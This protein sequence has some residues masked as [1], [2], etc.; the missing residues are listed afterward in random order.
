MKK[1]LSINLL[2]ILILTIIGVYII[3]L[4][5]TPEVKP[6]Y[7]RKD[8]QFTDALED[9]D[10]LNKALKIMKEQNCVEPTSWYYQ[11]AIHWV[12][13]TIK[14]INTPCLAYENISDL[15]PGWDAC[16]H[17]RTGAEEVN[18]LIWHRLY[19][20]HFEKIV[21][22]LSGKKDFALPYWNYTS[23]IHGS[24]SKRL[25]FTFRDT[26]SYLYESAR[27]DSINM[28]FPIRGSEMLNVLDTK[29]LMSQKTH[30]GFSACIDNG[31]HGAMHDYIGGATDTTKLYDNIITRS[32]TKVG[33]MGWVPTAAFDPVF[34]IHHANVD[35]LW[36]KWLTSKNGQNTTLEELKE[37]K[38]NFVFFDENGKQVTYTPEDIIKIIYTMDYDYDYQEV[39]PSENDKFIVRLNNPNYKVVDNKIDSSVNTIKLLDVR[40]SRIKKIDITVSFLDVPRGV[41]EVHLNSDTTFTNENIVGYMSF[42][43]SDHRSPG[44]TCI[45]GCC[46]E[47]INGRIQKKF[48]YD[49]VINNQ[50]TDA[51]TQINIIKRNKKIHNDLKIE[52]VTIF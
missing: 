45:R 2:I 15:R 28:G 1:F 19:I 21:R 40:A 33:L 46:G 7:V 34:W 18:F 10:A 23:N 4:Y 16:T 5:S 38:W 25:N 52:N 41:Y 35:Y 13:D 26:T 29:L 31:L 6:R 14:G 24:S 9:L 17:T 50:I 44:E 8:V 39:K 37:N 42:F 22:K 51:V 11:G 43:G 20:W 32:K 49:V 47:L 30:A 48:S 27:L 36:S 12:P 3:I